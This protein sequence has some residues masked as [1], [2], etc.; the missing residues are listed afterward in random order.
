M[1]MEKDFLKQEKGQDS[2]ISLSDIWN[3]SL[4]HI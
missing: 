4:I 2:T 3:L 1:I